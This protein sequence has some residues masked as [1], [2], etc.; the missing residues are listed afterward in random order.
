MEH[1]YEFNLKTRSSDNKVLL[2]LVG[3]DQHKIQLKFQKPLA[4]ISDVGVA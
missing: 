2:Y 4:N 1:I 3:C